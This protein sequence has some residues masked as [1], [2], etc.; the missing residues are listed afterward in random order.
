MDYT[1]HSYISTVDGKEDWYLFHK[2]KRPIA[3]VTMHG[4]GSHGD[5]IIK[6]ADVAE[7][8]NFLEKLDVSVISPNL[9]DNAWMSAPA[10][11]DLKNLLVSLKAEHN[12]KR[13]IIDSGSMGGTGAFIFAI[14][15]PELID[16]LVVLG[17]ST[18]LS[19]YLEWC[20]QPG[21]RPIIVEIH[22]AIA[23]AYPTPES[24]AAHDVCAH[25]DRLTMP[26]YYYHG[27]A[28]QT[29]PFSE[30]LAL[31]EKMSG[32]DNFHFFSI[33]DGNHDSPL[34]SFCEGLANV[35]AEFGET[36]PP[37]ALTYV[38]VLFKEPA[39]SGKVEIRYGLQACPVNFQITGDVFKV[40]VACPKT[41]LGSG[42]TV[43][44]ILANHS[45]SFFLRDVNSATPIFIP[46]YGVA[47]VP[48]DDPRS[49][50]QV[51]AD[52][53]AKKLTS[54]FD[55]MNAEPEETYEN[56]CKY[57]RNKSCP[58]W[59]GTGGDVRIFA[60]HEQN[61][62][63][64]TRDYEFFGRIR[65]RFH[66]R[67][68][69][70]AP[71]LPDSEYD[72]AFTIGPGAHCRPHITKRLEDG[73][74]PIYHATQDE[75][76][77]QYHVTAFATLANGPLGPGR[78]RGTDWHVAYA[79]TG[80]NMLSKEEKEAITPQIVAETDDTADMP[81]CII[82]I[83]AENVTQAPAYAWFKAVHIIQTGKNSYGEQGWN[84]GQTL[85]N[86]R[87]AALNLLE[88]QPMPQEEMAV[89]VPPGRS[90]VFEMRI[91]HQPSLPDRVA[92]LSAIDYAQHLNACRAFWQEKLARAAA[93]SVPE[94]AV[95]ER[96]R[97]GLCHLDLMTLGRTN[98]GPL[99]PTI[100]WYSPI[101]TESA[102]IIQYFDSMG[103]HRQA[104]RCI[105]FF[106]E[107][108]RPDGF[109]QNF[110]NY[111][112]E[113]GPVLW[114]AAEHFR[115]TQDTEWLARV[116]P[117]LIKSANYLLAWRERNKKD[118]YRPKGFYGM[119][120]GKVADPD[121]F[122]QSFFLNAGTYAGLSGL[123]ECLVHTAPEF[124]AQLAAELKDYG[125]DILTGLR[126]A[127]AHSPV[128]PLLDGTWAPR[129]AGWV[130]HL[131]SVTLFAE[132]GK[133]FTQHAGFAASGVLT[134][135]LYLAMTDLL[136]PHDE[137]LEMLLKTNQNP[138]TRENA[139]M[140]Q[141]Y[142]CRHDYAHIRR[143]EVKL[144]LKLFYNQFAALQDRQIYSF[145]EH[146][147]GASQY[148]THEE[149]W[150]LMQTRWMMYLEDGN[151]LD[152]FKAIPRKWLEPG[153]RI[154][155]HNVASH[156]GKINAEVVA[157]DHQIS[158]TYTIERP[159]ANVRIRLPHPQGLKAVKC[160]GGTYDAALETV[161][162]Q[163]TSGRVVLEF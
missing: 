9:R 82:R 67:Y 146:Y 148:K 8:Q 98:E 132:P 83:E 59:L 47:V 88:G 5:Q 57:D 151:T 30:A 140:T 22:D 4:H 73:V 153:K 76:D 124:A 62:T 27:A 106:L 99:L 147:H 152:L 142:Y 58:I 42:Q 87:V 71:D 133:W 150:F 94:V 51:A 37:E 61:H 65:P 163:T 125:S 118:E 114:T 66:S 154:M 80:V 10:V 113:T 11:E 26:I 134:G 34:P 39:V 129:P 46:E 145:W 1:R 41:A 38:R 77:I 128:V 81:V 131:G 33:P 16:A 111:E 40:P 35:F 36:V 31:N 138:V 48:A 102:P 158:C 49:Y 19:T 96:I 50:T 136:P 25:A 24:L 101:G 119:V 97:A 60:F 21:Q 130:E 18:S 121:D 7:R 84:N 155:L 78:V 160:S 63:S 15:H 70:A 143:G 72:L 137:M 117:K 6:R 115:Y 107:R 90:I 144:F 29:I 100:G 20:A 32:K 120:D 110:N 52:I 156:F 123:A 85:L 89:L 75:Q 108:Q 55:R 12:F 104:E 2:G 86:G 141:P 44:T 126:Y 159:V 92:V 28:D 53:A 95:D 127:L 103:W 79:C 109:I 43:V 122:Y 162:V 93:V 112:S 161:T 91:P 17:A 56:A 68:R 139:A 157:D 64:L 45:F 116:T 149:G 3:I 13:I 23:A 54:D 14:C 74:L 69:S 105:D 135:P